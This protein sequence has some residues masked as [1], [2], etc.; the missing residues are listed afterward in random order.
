MRIRKIVVG[1]AAAIALA[2][3]LSVAAWAC[4]TSGHFGTTW[5]CQTSSTCASPGNSLTKSSAA[6]QRINARA[7]KTYTLNYDVSTNDCHAGPSFGSITTDSTGKGTASITAPAT[8]NTYT[9]C[10]TRTDI[11]EATNHFNFVVT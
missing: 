9:A 11:N 6:F 2:L 8:A 3:T 4:T 5:F 7:S 10:P 1:G